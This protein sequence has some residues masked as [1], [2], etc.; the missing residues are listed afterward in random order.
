MAVNDYIRQRF[1][2]APVVFG[3]RSRDRAQRVDPGGGGAGDEPQR[4]RDGVGHRLLVAHLGV[5][6]FS[7]AAHD[8]RP[9]A[10]LC[11]GRE[12]EQAGAERDRAHGRR[13][14]AVHRRQ[15]LHP[16]GPAQHRHHGHRDEQPHLR[17]DRRAVFTADGSGDDGHHGAVY[18]HRPGVRR[19]GDGHGGRGD[20]CGAHDDLPRSADGGHHPQRRSFTRGFRWWR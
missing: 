20:L 7:H 6:G 14:R 12:A 10:G 16:R 17:D 8:P 9:G 19:G 11:H 2:P 1:F 4:D 5:H 3:V 18:Q 13:R 15:P